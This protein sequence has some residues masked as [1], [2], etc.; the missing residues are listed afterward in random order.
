[1]VYRKELTDSLRDRRTM[2]SMIV[3]PTILMPLL[4]FEVGVLSAT[5]FGRALQEVPQRDGVGWRRLAQGV[6]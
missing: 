1:M 5:L 4:T 6:G 3:I 2:I